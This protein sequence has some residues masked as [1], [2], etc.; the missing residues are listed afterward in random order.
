MEQVEASGAHWKREEVLA[1]LS[2]WKEEDIFRDVQSVSEKKKPVY[3]VI[4]ERL[5]GLGY[6]RTTTQIRNKIRRLKRD[7]KDCCRNNSTSGRARVGLP[8]VLAS[9][10]SC[11]LQTWRNQLLCVCV[12]V[13]VDVS[14]TRHTAHTAR[15]RESQVNSG[16]ICQECRMRSTTTRLTAI[17]SRL[18]ATR[19]FGQCGHEL[20]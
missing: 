1:L 16:S 19:F 18:F 10:K 6:S 5:A 3:G 11:T 4:A 13:R 7:Y 8:I 20:N 12:C 9:D 15:A 17:G 2:V 14:T